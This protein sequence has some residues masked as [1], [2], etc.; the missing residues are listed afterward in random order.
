[1]VALEGKVDSNRLAG[2]QWLA[3][4][5]ADGLVAFNW[6]Q[7][8]IDI[9]MDYTCVVNVYVYRPARRCLAGGLAERCSRGLR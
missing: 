6:A 4:E 7:A 1:M 2:W 9:D 8:S 5:R 3:V